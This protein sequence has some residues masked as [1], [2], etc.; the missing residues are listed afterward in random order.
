[1]RDTTDI[2]RAGGPDEAR[3]RRHSFITPRQ[4]LPALLAQTMPTGGAHKNWAS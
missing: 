1:M 3:G 2:S 4:G